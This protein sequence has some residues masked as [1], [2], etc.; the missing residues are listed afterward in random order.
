MPVLVMMVACST[1]QQRHHSPAALSLGWHQ[2]LQPSAAAAGSMNRGWAARCEWQP[3]QHGASWIWHAARAPAGAALPHSWHT[4][5]TATPL[6][7]GDFGPEG[8]WGCRAGRRP[9]GAALPHPNDTWQP[10][11]CPP[12][13]G[14]GSG[15]SA[16]GAVV[17]G[18][19][20]QAQLRPRGALGHGQEAPD[21]L[22]GR[23]AQGAQVLQASKGS[24]EPSRSDTA[25][26]GGCR[27]EALTATK[28][29][30]SDLQA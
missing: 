3:V 4:A 30:P 27:S 19:G 17:L 1:A 11:A 20:L 13:R 24:V 29:R 22:A 28:T 5:G 8:T 9:A 26:G 16:P 6:E 21:L 23:E 10:H 18:D 12:A 7:V 15:W 14:G 2:G 25:S